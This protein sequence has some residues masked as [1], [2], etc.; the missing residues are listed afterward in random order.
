M[1]LFFIHRVYNDLDVTLTVRVAS[2]PNFSKFEHLLSAGWIPGRKVDNSDQQYAGFRSNIPYLA[3]LLI[4][5]PVLRRAYAYLQ[6]TKDS[7]NSVASGDRLNGTSLTKKYTSGADTCKTRRLTFDVLFAF[8]YIFALHGSSAFK[9]LMILYINY[10]LATRLGREA[11]PL[12]TW[13]FNIGILFANELCSGYPYASFANLLQ[14]SMSF[15][16]DQATEGA[17]P[18]WGLFL[19]SYGG[20]IPRWEILFN[21]TVL[22][23]ISFNLDYYWASGHTNSSALEVRPALTIRS[24]EG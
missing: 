19:D 23:L 14:P 8:V 2:H 20:L 5:H 9:I 18:N 22:R 13:T 10:T 21:I 4:L 24:C 3:L 17:R 11:V 16:K 12:A 1:L 15:A 7:S 6:P